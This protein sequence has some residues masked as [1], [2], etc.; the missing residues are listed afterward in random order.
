MWKVQNAT[1]LGGMSEHRSTRPMLV[2]LLATRCC[3][4]EGMSGLSSMGPKL[5]LLLATRCHYW[6]YIWAQVNWTQVTTTLGHQM[7]LPGVSVWLKCKKDIW[8]FEH[9]WGL[10]SCF[11][12][13]FSMKEQRQIYH[14]EWRQE[15]KSKSNGP[16]LIGLVRMCIRLYIEKQ[17]NKKEGYFTIGSNYLLFIFRNKSH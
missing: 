15:I 9:T 17:Q 4:Q 12:E 13:V 5:V 6:G 2:P 1:I 7:P 3:Y 11:T 8:E 10:G 16:E 14:K